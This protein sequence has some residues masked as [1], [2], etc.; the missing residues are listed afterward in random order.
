LRLSGVD[1]YDTYTAVLQA[2]GIAVITFVL[3]VLTKDYKPEIHRKT[4]RFLKRYWYLFILLLVALLVWY[5]WGIYS[6]YATA[7]RF[8]NSEVAYQNCLD[9]VAG[10]S[11]FV[12]T[13]TTMTLSTHSYT[14]DTQKE[15]NPYFNGW[16]NAGRLGYNNNEHWEW[17]FMD[18][19]MQNHPDFCSE[20]NPLIIKSFVAEEVSTINE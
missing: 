8:H 12:P 3:L 10:L 2:V 17:G 18:W 7:Q 15:I 5:G 1:Y 20:F 4:W 13:S 16:E 11:T 6:T 19:M 9:K 14:F